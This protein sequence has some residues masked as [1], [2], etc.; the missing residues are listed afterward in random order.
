MT[1]DC[2]SRQKHTTFYR[3]V[4]ATRLNMTS[5]MINHV[6]M[7]DGMTPTQL[8]RLKEHKYSAEGQSLFEPVLQVITKF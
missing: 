3:F 6:I 1:D 4:A 2:D 5:N 7:S 8:K